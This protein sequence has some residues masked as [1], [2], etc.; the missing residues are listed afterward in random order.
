MKKLFALVLAVAMV[1]ALASVAFAADTQVGNGNNTVLVYDDNGDAL[2]SYDPHIYQSAA[3]AAA[4]GTNKDGK[5]VP[6]GKTLYI[7]FV[8]DAG[9]VVSD[10]DAVSALKVTAKWTE[11]GKYVKSVEIV[12]K[13]GAYMMA[14]KTTGSNDDAVD[15]EGTLYITGKAYATAT[16]GE[17]KVKVA[18]TEVPVIITLEYDTIDDT[19]AAANLGVTDTAR[20]YNFED[21]TTLQDEEFELTFDE[22]E[23]V[24]FTVDTTHQKDLVLKADTDEDEAVEKANPDANMDFYNFYGASFKKTG[25]LFIPADEGSYLY[26]IVDGAVKTVNAKYDDFDEGFYL[27]TKTLGYYVVSDIP[28]NTAATVAPAAEAAAPAA[29]PATGAAL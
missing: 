24:T 28:L 12:K 26:Q 27:N 23:D 22:M 14:I 2:V 18:K 6:Y 13:E 4:L 25:E 1:L 10:A 21:A 19:T 16:D 17:K 20:L 8:D 3:Q 7:P 9:N 15:V 5:N 29:N 11:N